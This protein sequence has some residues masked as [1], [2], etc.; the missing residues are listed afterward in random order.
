MRRDSA[1]C[2]WLMVLRSWAVRWPLS[3]ARMPRSS[4]LM[5]ASWCSRRAVCPAFRSPLFTP[6]A[7]R[8]C[9]FSLRWL[10][11]GSGRLGAD[12][13]KITAGVRASVTA[14]ANDAG[15]MARLLGFP[16]RLRSC[17]RS[18]RTERTPSAFRVLRRR[19]KLYFFQKPRLCGRFRVWAALV[20]RAPFPVQV[21]QVV[22]FCGET[23]GALAFHSFS[24]VPGLL[25]PAGAGTLTWLRLG[26]QLLNSV[27]SSCLL[28]RNAVF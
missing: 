5:L 17:C 14:I 22:L 11:V 4:L 23:P 24:T 18:L 10:M 6:W 12:S 26:A 19:R 21:V 1:F 25:G 16:R 8:S 20:E 2:W 3:W 7:M 28:H 9:W 13:A 15:F 27:H